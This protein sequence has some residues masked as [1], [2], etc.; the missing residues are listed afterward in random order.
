MLEWLND[1]GT[2]HNFYLNNARGTK[3]ITIEYK[4]GL[5]CDVPVSYWVFEYGPLEFPL[6][7][8]HITCK[9][10]LYVDFGFSSMALYYL[11]IML[12]VVAD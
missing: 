2:A 9:P 7:V 6:I 1:Y 4:I 8:C 10:T 11:G 3:M 12:H 5:Q